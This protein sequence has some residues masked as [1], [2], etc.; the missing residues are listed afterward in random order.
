M[1]NKYFPAEQQ[2]LFYPSSFKNSVDIKI[3]TKSIQGNQH[4]APVVWRLDNAI[5]RINHYPVDKC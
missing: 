1:Q 4:Q 2:I 3:S 5:H